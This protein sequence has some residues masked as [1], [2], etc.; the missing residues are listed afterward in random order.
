MNWEPLG[1]HTGKSFVTDLSLEILNS[2]GSIRKIFSASVILILKISSM[3][4]LIKLIVNLMP[5]STMFLN[6]TL[7]CFERQ[8]LFFKIQ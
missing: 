8:K 3:K 7:L 2:S 1:K 4:T 5:Q 6:I